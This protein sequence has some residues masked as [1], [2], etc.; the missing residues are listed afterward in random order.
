MR[1]YAIRNG[2]SLSDKAL[3]YDSNEGDEIESSLIR[4]L[5]GKDYIETEEDVF[6]FLGVEYVEPCDRSANIK[7]L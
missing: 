7:F 3:R 2:Y 4:E 5:L 1:N 6:L